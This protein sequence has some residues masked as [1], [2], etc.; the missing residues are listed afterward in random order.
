M[1]HELAHL[2]AAAQ[3]QQDLLL[4]V[5]P[6]QIASLR[7]ATHI[8]QCLGAVKV[9]AARLEVE[10]DVLRRFD[11]IQGAR[12]VNV[13]PAQ[14]VHN[15]DK[16]FELELRVQIDRDAEPFVDDAAQQFGPP[17]GFPLLA[18]VIEGVDFAGQFRIGRFD[19]HIPGNGDDHHLWQLLVDH[20]HHDHVR[21]PGWIAGTLIAAEH[22]DGLNSLA[23]PHQGSLGFLRLRHGTESGRGRPGAN[24]FFPCGDFDFGHFQNRRRTPRRILSAA[25]GV[26]RCGQIGFLAGRFPLLKI[27]DA[28]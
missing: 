16:P 28:D 25:G 13:N 9:V 10:I 26:R 15:A 24:R 18:P 8:G 11:V 4:A 12:H 3:G 17:A 5:D 6:G 23:G 1:G 19:P 22:E 27:R 2:E 7:A 21:S 14:A 20:C